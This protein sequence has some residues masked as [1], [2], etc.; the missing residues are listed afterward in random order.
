LP[1]NCPGPSFVQSY[2]RHAS[3]LGANC[4]NQP[5][6]ACDAEAAVALRTRTVIS[7]RAISAWPVGNRPVPIDV[8]SAGK[9]HRHSDSHLYGKS[10]L[11]SVCDKNAP[12]MEVR[13]QPGMA[14]DGAGD[15]QNTVTKDQTAALG[16]RVK[17][18][19][20]AVVLLTGSGRSPDLLHVGRI[21]LYDS[22]CPRTRQPYHA[23]TGK[24]ETDSTKLD[25]RERTVWR[26][27]RQALGELLKRYQKKDFFLRADS[28]TKS[29]TGQTCSNSARL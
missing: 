9:R 20:A 8:R 22:Q 13:S 28:R 27:S 21:E 23:A 14:G 25:Q 11:R 15:F 10:V 4:P 17:S 18:G 29:S 7:T 1:C 5:D 6:S 3:A 24:L 19:W 26:V 16:F 2:G 12:A